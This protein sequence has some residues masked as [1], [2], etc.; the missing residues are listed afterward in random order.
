M[1]EAERYVVRPIRADEWPEAKA[2]RLLAL[3]D[4]VAPIAFLQTHAEVAAEPDSYWQV[5]AQQAATGIRRCQFVA[6]DRNGGLSGTVTVLI[7]DVDSDTP[8]DVAGPLCQAH[9]V[10]VFL[11]PEA[12]GSGVIDALLEAA[13]AW[14]WSSPD[15]ARVRLY[16]H[17][18]NTRAERV[19]W[20]HGFVPSGEVIPMKG[21][22]SKVERE[23]VLSRPKDR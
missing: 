22:S 1:S 23:L 6:E 16:V 13:A 20:R 8:C 14:A 9:I 5:R 4:P 3:N 18:D 2:L 7:E 15:V 17:E 21:D 12:R 19:Y 10:G 11:R